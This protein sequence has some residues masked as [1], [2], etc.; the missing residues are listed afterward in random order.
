MVGF[1]L[2]RLE[3]QGYVL[4]LL[5][6]LALYDASLVVLR[7]GGLLDPS[8]PG[9]LVLAA[10][11][12]VSGPGSWAV[13]ASSGIGGRRYLESVALLG[14]LG[15]AYS[16]L[17]TQALR[18]GIA[19]VEVAAAPL[20][21]LTLL[22][23]G[24]MELLLVDDA[25]RV[26]NG[27]TRRCLGGIPLYIWPL[28]VLFALIV[29]G[30]GSPLAA[31]V[32]AAALLYAARRRPP[33]GAE[34]RCTAAT[35]LAVAA[36]LSAA[37]APQPLEAAA[38]ALLV[39]AA[40]MAP[41]APLPKRGAE[42]GVLDRIVLLGLAA[43]AAEANV[44]INPGLLAADTAVYAAVA[45]AGWGLTALVAEAARRSRLA[46]AAA[47]SP[48]LRHAAGFALVLAGLHI[49]RLSADPGTV[50]LAA[51]AGAAAANTVAKER[52]R[53]HSLEHQP[54]GEEHSVWGHPS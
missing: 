11:F 39:Y 27:V 45:A 26:L 12:F 52:L 36:L 30:S 43:M 21:G 31:A 7:L 9:W 37:V 1:A 2:P 15:V 53:L 16:A 51:A 18:G 44:E 20:A 22:M 28:M 50:L 25:R 6:T 42:A 35:S 34:P 49:L 33:R 5:S 3:G 54:S 23:M 41:H 19:R 46:G 40:V 14:P 32:Y 48:V 13:A 8:R 17:L 4:A 47:N 38:A 10:A 29:V 24:V